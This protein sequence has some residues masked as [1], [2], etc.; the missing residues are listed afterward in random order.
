MASQ[1]VVLMVGV[2]VGI[3]ALI[4]I[5][6]VQGWLPGAGDAVRL[7]GGRLVRD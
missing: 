3:L 1:R 2:G 6:A 4:G 7:E 5:A